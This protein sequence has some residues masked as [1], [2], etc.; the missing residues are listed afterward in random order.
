MAAANGKYATVFA[1]RVRSLF[2]TM[3]EEAFH[4][5]GLI[6]RLHFRDTGRALTGSFDESWL[7]E[8][9]NELKNPKW[10][11]RAEAALSI[12][13][14]GWFGA[15]EM[16]SESSRTVTEE[17]MLRVLNL[18]EKVDP[19]LDDQVLQVRVSSLWALAW[20]TER[21]PD[22]GK[23]RPEIFKRVL[24]KWM[25]SQHVDESYLASW[26]I[27]GMN[28]V[29]KDVLPFGETTAAL[30]SFIEGVMNVEEGSKYWQPLRNAGKI[31]KY[32]LGESDL[33]PIVKDVRYG[34]TRHLSQ[35]AKSHGLS[36]AASE[37]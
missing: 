35:I 33:A 34:P 10:Q 30:Q 11:N 25:E 19:L 31:L 27:G 2:E 6:V 15:K 36:L 24:A 22:L 9:E 3:P 16:V 20:L 1:E 5:G 26:I 23:R 32:Y 29:P 18:F 8:A 17:E 14:Q 13:E 28:M 21:A 37:V 12:M 7:C 4:L